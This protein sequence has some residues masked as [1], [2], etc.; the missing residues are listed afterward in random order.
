MAPLIDHTKIVDMRLRTFDLPPLEVS[1][2]ALGSTY[3][4]RST[5]SHKYSLTRVYIQIHKSANT[6]NATMPEKM[7]RTNEQDNKFDL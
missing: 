7:Q 4:D 5:S 6:R 2:L 1:P 3:V